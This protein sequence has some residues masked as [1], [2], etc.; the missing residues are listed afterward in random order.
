M[1]ARKF[2]NKVTNSKFDIIE[3]FLKILKEKRIPYCVIGGFAINAY[4]EPLITLDFDCVIDEKRIGELK[5]VLKT[6]GFKVKTHPY[7]FEIKHPESDLRIQIQRDKRF[8]EFI[9]KAKIKKVLGYKIKVAS[10]EDLLISKIWCMKDKTRNK[11][12]REKDN[13]DIKRLVEKF[14][15][16]KKILKNFN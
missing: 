11:L 10:K 9:K 8:Q 4:C 7:T 3:E 16:L 1:N 5:E 12:K 2:F 15:E 6:K 13:L 14:P